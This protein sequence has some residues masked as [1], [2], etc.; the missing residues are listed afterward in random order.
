MIGK[1]S[2][3]SEAIHYRSLDDGKKSPL[4]GDNTPSWKVQSCRK[5]T[6]IIFINVKDGNF[7]QCVNGTFGGTSATLAVQVDV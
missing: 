6:S 1:C 7:D 3:G 2:D 4:L 5:L